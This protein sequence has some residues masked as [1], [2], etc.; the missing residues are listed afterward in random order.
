MGL[1]IGTIVLIIVA[2]LV[3]F[4]VLHRVLD[5]MRLTD[6]AALV[7]ILL[8]AAGTFVDIPISRGGGA[9]IHQRGRRPRAAWTG[10]LVDGDC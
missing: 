9:C 3:F 4:G 6:R 2:I 1:P 7:I 8:M 5:R 10:H